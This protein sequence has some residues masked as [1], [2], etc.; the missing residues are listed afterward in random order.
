MGN[1]E[2]LRCAVFAQ[3]DWDAGAA[4]DYET[5]DCYFPLTGEGIVHDTTLIPNPELGLHSLEGPRNTGIEI[6]QGPLR[7]VLHYD[8]DEPMLGRAM[9]SVAFVDGGTALNT[10]TMTMKA[11]PDA[12]ISLILDKGHAN[13]G[14][15]AAIP[16]GF[17]I[18]V[19][20]GLVMVEYPMMG[21][22]MD[23]TASVT[24]GN[25]TERSTA[26]FN[27]VLFRHGRI[28]INDEDG[29]ALVDPTH[30]M[31]DLWSDFTLTLNNGK[32]ALHKNGLY[33]V[34]PTRTGRKSVTGTV[35]LQR[36]TSDVRVADI[37][38]K[39]LKKMAIEFT[40]P[41]GETMEFRLPAVRFDSGIPGT[42]G[43][44]RRGQTLNF[45]AERTTANPTGESDVL[46]YIVNT[47]EAPDP[48]VS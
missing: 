34:L 43:P 37:I 33:T 11:E 22:L 16:N 1:G 23:E 36:H 15:A 30:E 32:A 10:L 42:D 9:G 14:V 6:V 44:G 19:S 48:S 13:W 5:G 35:T 28:L 4:P 39:T 31:A 21:R 20:D 41:N 24:W 3:A 47:S 8:G 12:A 45:S 40:G 26:L 17:T 38:S 2:E 18:S 46:P 25:V 7:R 29:V 27:H